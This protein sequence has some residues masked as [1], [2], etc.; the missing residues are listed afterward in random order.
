MEAATRI[1]LAHEPDFRLGKVCIRPALRQ[2][3]ADDGRDRVVEPRVMQ[4][5]VALGRTPGTILTR[6]ELVTACWDGRIVGD[7]A[8]NRVMSKLRQ[9]A[10]GIGRDSF[11]V[12]TIAKVGYR[13]MEANRDSL[14]DASPPMA[15]ADTD[16]AVAT[17]TTSSRRALL[18][19][20]AASACVVAAGAGAWLLSRASDQADPPPEVADLMQQARFASGQASPEGST[21]ALGI[22]RQVVATAPH[23]ADGW[24]ALALSYSVGSRAAPPSVR[25]GLRQRALAALARCEAL[26]PGNA[27][28]TLARVNLLPLIGHW[29]LCERLLREGLDRH[30]GDVGLSE[31]LGTVLASVGRVDEAIGPFGTAYRDAM[32]M[33]R[34]FYRYGR[35]LWA[36]GRLEECEAVLTRAGTLYPTHFAVWF[37]R[38]YIYLY[39]GRAGEALAMADRIPDRPTGI[40]ADNFN[41]IRL[42]AQALVSSDPADVQ[43]ALD[44]NIATA[45]RGAGFAEN[46][47]QFACVLGD[48][49]LASTI[50]TGYFLGRGFAVSDVR[51]T[52]EQGGHTQLADRRTYFLFEPVTAPLR[53]Q[54][55]FATILSATGLERYWRGAGVVPDFR[56]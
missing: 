2:L 5:L 36:A 16:V 43:R 47:I 6:D 29:T 10:A 52:P 56:R 31:A 39:T 50:A 33:P 3:Q 45:H 13:L 53:R 22:L 9:L 8:I 26:D 46:V 21:Q 4:V 41:A 24:G 18:I 23:Y 55:S 17:R 37:T 14:P 11:Q 7:D 1:T 28:G 48:V 27:L 49:A 15:A 34:L 38:F 25:P 35:T 42:V 30:P 19:G 51:F 40:P 32:P 20:S 44:A 12:E 54:A